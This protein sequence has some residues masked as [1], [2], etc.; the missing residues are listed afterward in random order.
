MIIKLKNTYIN[1]TLLILL[2]YCLFAV[3]N[4]SMCSVGNDNVDNKNNLNEFSFAISM[5]VKIKSKC[6]EFIQQ[7]IGAIANQTEDIVVN[8][9]NIFELT[10]L[11]T[12][13]ENICKLFIN[14]Y[15]LQESLEYQESCEDRD[16]NNF[17]YVFFKIVI[18]MYVITSVIGGTTMF[19]MTVYDRKTRNDGKSFNEI[20]KNDVYDY[21]N[22]SLE[23]FHMFLNGSVTIFN[24]AA[25]LSA[26]CAGAEW[27]FGSGEDIQKINKKIN[28]LQQKML[29]FIYHKLN[30]Y[31]K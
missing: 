4:V 31:Q 20:F 29:Q 11:M 21:A 10:E 18:P 28:Q 2:W 14:M 19:G 17:Q 7:V 22:K 26:L 13:D 16:K 8:E 6:I 5:P 15:Q 25:C 24:C 3:N 12:L 1:N 27:L 23:K 9:S 30:N